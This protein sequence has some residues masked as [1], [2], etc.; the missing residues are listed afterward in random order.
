MNVKPFATNE[1][2]KIFRMSSDDDSYDLPF[3][4]TME[5]SYEWIPLPCELQRLFN[6]TLECK[7]SDLESGKTILAWFTSILFVVV[8]PT[9]SFVTTMR[10]GKVSKE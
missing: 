10:S 7:D 8:F 1:I 5:N 3:N 2:V 9:V 4:F 6:K